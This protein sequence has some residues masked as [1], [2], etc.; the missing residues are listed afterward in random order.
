MKCEVCDS[1]IEAGEL[2]CPSCSAIVQSYF[3][4][5]EMIVIDDSF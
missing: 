1:D 4:D 3:L 2:H 5:E